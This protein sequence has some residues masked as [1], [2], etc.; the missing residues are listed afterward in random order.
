M[1]AAR[2]PATISFIDAASC[3]RP[4]DSP[5]TVTVCDRVG[6]V[7]TAT[8]KFQLPGP[9]P[10]PPDIVDA[11]EGTPV[12]FHE[13]PMLFVE[14]IEGPIWVWPVGVD[15]QRGMQAVGKSPE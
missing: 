7:L 1:N 8:V 15:L 2:V 13:Q 10:L 11:Q 4:N 14:R 9:V 5:A 3:V 6:P 12:T